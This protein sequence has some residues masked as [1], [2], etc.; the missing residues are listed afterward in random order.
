MTNIRNDVILA[1]KI[2][3][4]KFLNRLFCR[5][6]HVKINIKRSDIIKKNS[7][8][9]W[10]PFDKIFDNG[11]ILY[12]NSYIKLMKIIPI[13]YNLKSNLEKEAILNSYRLFLKTCNFNIQIVIQTKKEDL[14]NHFFVLKEIS[15]K[16]ENN[17][18]R[19]IL[20]MY[21]DYIKRRVEENKSSSK[22]FYLIVKY[23][24]DSTI[25]EQED[26]LL[27]QN[28]ANNFLNECFLKIKENLSRCGNVVY[29]IDSKDDVENV[30]ISFFSNFNKGGD[31][32]TKFL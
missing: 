9:E 5:K 20:E 19:E 29:D 7:T 32:S 10:L 17:K 16:E 21:L 30:L 15:Q 8:K 4:S 31:N 2:L 18:I 3:Y 25:K 23:V 22:N 27:N 11:V 26:K 14:S 13:N 1:Y 24:A 6:F 28:I 12:K